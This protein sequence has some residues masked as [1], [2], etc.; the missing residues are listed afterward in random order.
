MMDCGEARRRMLEADLAELEPSAA[1]ELGTHLAACA[2]CRA[3]AHAIR[4]AERALADRLDAAR[5]PGDDAEAVRLAAAAATWRRRRATHR[6]FGAGFALA[7]AAVA[8]L[9]LLPR[10]RPRSTAPL[11]ATRAAALPGFS[12]TAAPGQQVMVLHPADPNIVVVW[13][14][15]SRR[16]S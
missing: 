11:A 10:G 8:G 3:A 6:R 2:A 9:I 4:A 5:P 16:P 13:F 7:A 1:T 12:V 14:F 15:S